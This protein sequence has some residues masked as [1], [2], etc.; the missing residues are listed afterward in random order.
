MSDVA[1]LR[2]HGGGMPG[3]QPDHGHVP[4]AAPHLILPPAE[5][6]CDDAATGGLHTLDLHTSARS[7]LPLAHL[8][9][10]L[11]DSISTHTQDGRSVTSDGG[12]L[13]SYPIAC[14]GGSIAARLGSCLIVAQVDQS[15]RI[16]EAVAGGEL[17]VA[18]IG[19]EVDPEVAPA[20]R[21]ITYAEDQLVRA[22]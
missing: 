20:L 13:G 14:A 4:H 21:A 10:H 12:H 8:M 6:G 3:G 11:P 7:N 22:P 17:D 5:P 2:Q 1:Q 16:C 9:Q 15:R 19:G 18:I